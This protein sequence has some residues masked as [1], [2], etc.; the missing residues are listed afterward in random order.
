LAPTEISLDSVYEI[1]KDNQNTLALVSSLLMR[2]IYGGMKC[3]VAMMS[4]YTLV[5]V[6]RFIGNQDTVSLLS[7]SKTLHEIRTH[8]TL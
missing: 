8:L 5:W 4:N 6:D 1:L 7:T 3:D 2:A